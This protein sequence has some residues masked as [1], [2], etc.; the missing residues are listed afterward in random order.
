MTYSDAG[1]DINAGISL[2]NALK[3]LAAS[4]CRTGCKADLGGFG[5]FF[6]LKA[7]G[8]SDPLLVSGT[9]GVGTK[10]KVSW[11]SDFG[12]IINYF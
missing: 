4:T 8:Y 3:P 11:L 5:G 7:A 1:V 2:V 9:D 12:R 6:D 10:L